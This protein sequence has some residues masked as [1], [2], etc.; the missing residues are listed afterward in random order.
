MPVAAPA[1]VVALDRFGA[2][3]ATEIARL[4]ERLHP[5]AT[6]LQTRDLFQYSAARSASAPSRHAPMA[7]TPVEA[8]LTPAVV[9]DAPPLKLIGIAEDGQADAVVRTAIVSAPG[10]VL[11][12]KI[13]DLVGDRHRVAGISTTAVELVDTADDSRLTLALP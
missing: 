1:S 2:A 12:V 7:P 13:G 8:S 9:I 6:P 10:D 4:H 3:L 5:T 11:L